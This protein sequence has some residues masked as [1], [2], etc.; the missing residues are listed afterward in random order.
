M[1]HAAI[2]AVLALEDLTVGERLAAFSLA[3]FANREQRAWPGTRLAAARAGLSRSQYLVSRSGLVQRGLVVVETPGGGRGQSPS[4]LLG[5][6][7]SGPW[8]EADVNAKLLESVLSHSRARGSAR[9]LLATLAAVADE[10]CSVSAFS[11]DEIR[12]AAGMADST[13]RRARAA[14][15]SSDELLLQAAGGG[16]GNANHWIIRD[17]RSV[18][19]APVSATQSRPRTPNARPLIATTRRPSPTAA[20]TDMPGRT[21]STGKSPGKGPGLSGVS[22]QNPGQ[23]RTV[24]AQTPPQTPP[25]TPPQT[26]SPNARAGREPQNPRTQEDPPTPLGGGNDS[27]SV[28]IVDDYVTDRGRR[29]QRTVTVEL[30]EARRQVFAPDQAAVSTWQQTRCE[31]ERLV[32]G[33]AFAIWLSPLELLAMDPN[34]VLLLGGPEATRGWISGRYGPLLDRA[35]QRAGRPVRLATDRELQLLRALSG[36]T[37]P[38]LNNPLPREHQEAV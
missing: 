22:V 3:S 2:A 23:N 8:L 25:E 37:E 13:Y 27:D 31:V 1:S 12:S 34:G 4:V 29:R 6:G 33:T 24:S 30:D 10:N 36:P 9:A 14:L 26:P 16:R 28:T 11:T 20:Q 18:N 7:N 17:P 15:L 38:F 35:G 21:V 5:F 32:S 19:P